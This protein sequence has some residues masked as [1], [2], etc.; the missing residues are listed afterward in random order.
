[1]IL[2]YLNSDKSVSAKIAEPSKKTTVSVMNIIISRKIT[3]RAVK[4]KSFRQIQRFHNTAFLEFVSCATVHFAE[5]MTETAGI[6]D[7]RFLKEL[8]PIR[9]YQLS[10]L[11]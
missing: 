6:A 9:V 2:K 7:L 11:I 8:F 10:R 4:N 3:L 1:M 5:G